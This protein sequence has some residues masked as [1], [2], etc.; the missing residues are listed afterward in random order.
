MTEQRATIKRRTEFAGTGAAIQGLGL[1]APFVGAL[2]GPPGIGLGLIVAVIM[3][4]WGSGKSM[5]WV[6]SACGNTVPDR[7][8]TVC[9]ACHVP[10]SRR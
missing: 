8:V 1:L 9:A 6:C 5:R 2:A 7:R 4:V 3:L 10:L